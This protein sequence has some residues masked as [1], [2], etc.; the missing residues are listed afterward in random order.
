MQ[1]EPD[2][3]AID[4]FPAAF[5]HLWLF[6][7]QPAGLGEFEQFFPYQSQLSVKSLI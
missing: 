5:Q 4:H 6:F 7:S 3:D 2:K 1:R